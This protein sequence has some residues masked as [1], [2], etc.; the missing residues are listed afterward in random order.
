MGARDQHDPVAGAAMS[1]AATFLRHV[2]PTAG[3]YC[4]FVRRAGATKGG[5]NHFAPTIEDLARQQLAADA[6]GC[7]VWHACGSVREARRDAAGTKARD[8][9]F[10]RTGHNIAAL[11]ALWLDVDAGEGKPYRDPR[12]AAEDV[13][14]FCRDA[15][16]PAPTLVASGGGCHAY[17]PLEADVVPAQWQPYADGLKAACHQHGLA[18]D[19]ARTSD[20]SSVLRTPGTHNRKRGVVVRAG[21]LTGPYRLEQF[22]HLLTQVPADATQNLLAGPLPAHLALRANA[23]PLL[24]KAKTEEYPD[25]YAE[26]IAEKCAQLRAFRD[27]GGRLQEPQWYKGLGV[28][29]FCVDSAKGHEW[30]R[31]DPRYDEA[32]TQE[33][34]ERLRQFR[35]TRCATFAESNPAGCEGCPFREKVTSPIE[36]GYRPPESGKVTRLSDFGDYVRGEGG[37]PLAVLASVLYALRTIGTLDGMFAYDEMR[38]AVV[39]ARPLRPNGHWDVRPITDVDVGEVQE[40][41]Q[42]FSLKRLAIDTMHQAIA[43]VARARAFHPIRDWLAELRWDGRRRIDTWLPR[44]IGWEDSAYAREVGRMF[45]VA[46]VA[47]VFRPGCQADYML[48]L[49]GEQG[50]LKSSACRALAGDEWFSDS[51][52]SLHQWGKDA[53]QHMRGKWLIEIAEMHAFDR[54]DQALLKSFITR[55]EE[56]YRPPHGRLEVREPRQALFIGTTNKSMYLRDETGGRRYWP[57]RCG[58]IDLDALRADRTQLL[59]E[60]TAA[61]RAGDRWWPTRDF[62]RQ[63]IA[64]QQSR[65]YEEDGWESLIGAWLEGKGG[66]TKPAF[67]VDAARY[68]RRVTISE[69]AFGA[70]GMEAP[71]IGTADQRRIA[72]ALT[73]LK[74]KRQNDKGTDG[75]RWWVPEGI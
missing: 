73:L 64:P 36:L 28:I 42:Q 16:L 34:M 66:R 35:P 27:T 37:K 2:L 60:A 39:L 71:R 55:R 6:R 23:T 44:Y 65:R 15:Q 58:K 22:A 18:A 17:W 56:I 10:G 24:E 69:V 70:L 13:L 59:A 62:E 54:A 19:P 38:N 53:A 29:A 9:R 20:D 72:A 49:E 67:V 40:W 26:L 1:D 14:R 68:G 32:D 12:A 61:F 31:A 21:P 11:R 74:W 8:R 47:R 51:L 52:P 57:G 63:H 75:T 3:P 48:V 25:S 4:Y 41:L 45:M 5:Q 30:S 43:I 46:L 50:E 33:R 7:S